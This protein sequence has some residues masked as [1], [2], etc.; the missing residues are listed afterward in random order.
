[1]SAVTD[2]ALTAKLESP[3]FT[4]G[5]RDVEPLFSLLAVADDDVA[6]RVERA[7]S[8]L[9]DRAARR[10]AETF[11]DAAPPLRARLC[12]LVGRIFV[13][14]EIRE[15]GEWL[16]H[17]LD[18]PD[19]KTRRRAAAALG[20][21]RDPRYEAPLLARFGRAVEEPERRALAASLGSVG[22]TAALE[23]LS[24]LE[25]AD[26]ELRRIVGEARVKIERTALRVERGTI[27]MD[28]APRAP[29]DL[30]LHVRA[31]LE[32]LL[33]EELGNGWQARRAGRGR[34]ALTVA[35][36]LRDVFRARTFMHLGFPLRAETVSGGDVAAS[37]VRALTSDAAFA[38]VTTFT[39]GPIRYRLDWG[40]GRRRAATFDVAAR[41]RRA[42]PE[43]VNDP[44]EALWEAVVNVGDGESGNVVRVE[45]WPRGIVDERFSYRRM[46]LP[47]SSHPTTAAALARVAGVVASDVVWD[48]FVGAGTEL[49]ERALLGPYAALYGSDSDPRALDAALENLRAA[50]VTRFQLAEGDARSW[51]PSARPSL[52]I[53]NPPFGRRVLPRDTI[54]P[55]FG[56]VLENIST[57]LLDGGRLVWVSPIPRATLE[58]AREAGFSPSRSLAVDL[59]GVP[60][61][62]QEFRMRDAAPRRGA[63]GPSRRKL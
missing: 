33:M 50:S 9:G 59:G 11:T 23:A 27:L 28:V 10:A 35:R 49:V 13:T 55:L 4:P 5:A 26:A 54:R 40:R 58:M 51:G 56:A 30:L 61:E 7:L 53:T 14:D 39:R 21:T 24:A 3:G 12:S 38:I 46:T 32:D 22:R 37:V 34:V 52:V 1:L 2:S 36:P 41:V 60:A 42:R 20:K 8:R 45:L 43:L 17:R 15:F 31:G 6:K 25:P 44:T 63:G 18:D 57:R 62:I 47:A 19:P 16:V 48:P 29:T